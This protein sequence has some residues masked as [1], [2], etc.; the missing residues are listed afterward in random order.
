MRPLPSIDDRLFPRNSRAAIVWFWAKYW[1][2]FFLLLPWMLLRQV[3]IS[4]HQ[5][6]GAIWTWNRR[7]SLLNGALNIQFMNNLLS[8]PVIAIFGERFTAIHYRDV[9]IDPGPVF[10]SRKLERYLA[11]NTGAIAAIIATHAH[12]EHIGNT[13]L[14][15]RL[16]RAPIYASNVT[17]EAIRNPES[18]S[19][20]RRTFIGQPERV[21][22]A[23]LRGLN[24]SIVTPQ[25][26]L[27]TIESPG[28]CAGH[29]SLFDAE[30]GILFAGDSFMHTV[31][32]SPNQDVSSDAWIETL[33][34]YAQLPIRTM[35]GAHG[36]VET[37]DENIPP[38]WFVVARSDPAAML[39]EKCAFLKWARAVVAEGETRG[40][41]YSVIEACLFPWQGW[42][43]WHNW[44]GDES[45]RL[46]SAGE[47][48]RTFFVRSLSRTP[49]RVPPRFPPFARLANWLFG[50]KKATKSG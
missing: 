30:R 43:S 1:A 39:I 20:M 11:Q 35:V 5:L 48:S 37:L 2:W 44:F 45:G 18:I 8:L 3:F 31:F 46:F 50:R 9:L 42:W 41:P 21:D 49:E 25:T 10:G 40:L 17:L 28:H 23:D 27:I 7:I 38:R 4:G 36:Y 24:E 13:G 33:E 47:F 19:F 16:T 12:E 34:R 15:A 26:R 6:L 29:A 14:A 32:T 22:G